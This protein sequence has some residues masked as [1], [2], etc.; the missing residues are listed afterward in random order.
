MTASNSGW[1]LP[2]ILLSPYE[3]FFLRRMTNNYQ[4]KLRWLVLDSGLFR[5]ESRDE[6][7]LE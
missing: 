4:L 1:N 2:A 5:T 7:N 6:S 3:I